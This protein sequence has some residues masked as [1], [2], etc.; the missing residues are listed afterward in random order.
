MS[1]YSGEQPLVSVDVIPLH[2]T[3]DGALQ[4]T[5]APRQFEPHLGELA[6][7]GVLMGR[8]RSVDAAERALLTKAGIST[9]VLLRDVGVF[10]S[11]ARDPRGPTM[12]VAKVA[13]GPARDLAPGGTATPVPVAGV[14]D[15]PFDHAAMIDAAV[16]VLSAQLWTDRE[17]ARAVLGA[18][19]TTRLATGL[20]REL[21]RLTGQPERANPSNMR[22]RLVATGWVDPTEKVELPEH[23]TGRPSTV[24]EWRRV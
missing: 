18:S 10:D 23:G 22:R 12:A 9:T 2:L 13:L 4:V 8:E 6:L 20:Q 11:P 21:E 19:F 14:G 16:R 24:W 7:P 5:L 1:T 17:V 15:L 3:P